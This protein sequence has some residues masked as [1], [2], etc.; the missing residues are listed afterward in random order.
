MVAMRLWCACVL[1]PALVFSKDV[2]Q[3]R[4]V[5]HIVADDLR[6][7]LHHAYGSQDVETP[8]L[9]ALTAKSTV[10]VNAYCQQAV[11]SPS[12]NSFMSGLRPDTTKAWNFKNYWRQVLPDAKSLPQYFKESG[13]LALGAG[14][15]YHSSNPPKHDEPLSWSPEEDGGQKYFEPAWQRCP[16]TPNTTI[17]P[18]GCVNDTLAMEED[19]QTLNRTLQHL[20]LAQQSGKNFYVGVGF[21]RPHTD[22]IVPEEFHNKY[23]H[24]DIAAAAHPLMPA[25]VPDMACINTMGIRTANASYPWTP[26]TQAVPTP[27]QIEMRKFY[28]ASISWI[29]HLVG[30]LLQ[31]LAALN[32]DNSTVIIF[33]SDHG[34]FLGES[35]EWEKKMLFETTNR[36]PLVIYDPMQPIY[37]RNADLVELIDVFPTAAVLA[38]LPLPPG[39][40]GSPMLDAQGLHAIPKDA[41]FSQYPRCMK[42]NRLTHVLCTGHMPNQ[43]WSMGY[44]IRT[45]DWRYTEWR[46]WDRELLKGVW[47]ST[48]LVAQELYN[49]TG[50]DADVV[51]N[52]DFVQDNLVNNTKYEDVVKKL[53]ERLRTQFDKPSEVLV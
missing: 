33:H 29:D 47:N 42:G 27:V 39:V 50:H 45:A 35:G 13:Y 25:S 22:W 19:Y 28:Y 15:L 46:Q 53:S 1:I 8:N 23:S 21:H 32:L 6:P 52:F 48:G 38:G 3:R 18:S 5:L 20:Q 24:K 41:A 44:S 10:F 11:C 14:K 31:E 43:F 4:N 2:P 34:Y 30:L 9:D 12:R 16:Q 26:K 7:N 40:E 51:D 49:H 36:V 37:K 17:H